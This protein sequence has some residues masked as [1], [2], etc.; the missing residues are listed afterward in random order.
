MFSDKK[1]I[2]MVLRCMKCDTP[3]NDPD[4][5]KTT[6]EIRKEND[7]WEGWLCKCGY[8]NALDP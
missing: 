7:S 5:P 2:L 4:N 8:Y 1:M 6:I 3:A